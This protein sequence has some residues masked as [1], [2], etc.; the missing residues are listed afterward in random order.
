MHLSSMQSQAHNIQELEEE[1][2][3]EDGSEICHD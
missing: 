3:E 1:E 2:E